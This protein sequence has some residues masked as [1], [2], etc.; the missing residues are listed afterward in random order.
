VRCFALNSVDGMQRRK[1]LGGLT[2]V[3]V[4]SVRPALA[5][6]TGGQKLADAARAQVGITTG[7]DPAW[8][9]I[10]YPGGDVPR[11]TGVCADVVIRAARD[12]L[13]LD[14][15]KLVHEDMVKNFS[16]YP[17]RKAW[18][19]KQPDANID[20]RRVLN[21][22]TYWTRVGA[23][24]WAAGAATPGDGFPKPME[25]GDLV[26]WLLNARLPHVG[27]VVTASA[28]R[29]VVHNIGRGAEES[30]LEDFHSEWAVG[31]YR[32]PVAS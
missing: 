29:R 27:I 16:A 5:A 13:G 24:L 2:A 22:E 3:C 10:G 12:G 9:Q 19:S 18:G 21:L 30:S 1:F 15:Q 28:Q 31:H 11:S 20:H 25:V 4:A 23:R 8:T 32:W 26:T 17:A 6:S 14:L 7:Y